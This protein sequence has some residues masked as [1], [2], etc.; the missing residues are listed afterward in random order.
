GLAL[1]ASTGL[2]P[3]AVLA[4]A[5]WAATGAGAWAIIAMRWI[6]GVVSQTLGKSSSEIYYA[7]IR[8]RERRRIKPALDTLVERWS[9]AAV[10]VL[11]IV[12]RY[13]LRLHLATIAV[14][15]AVLSAP[16][17][18]VLFL[19]TRQYGL[20]FREA[21]SRRWIE[22]E[23]AAESMRLPSARKAVLEALRSDD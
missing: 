15:T 3:G 7:A 6:Q 14:G 16:W 1:G 22:P 2:Q 13:V 5:E 19:L 12:G 8:P 10:G 23:L 11:L 18:V 20:A 17:L 21:L 9:D 4:F